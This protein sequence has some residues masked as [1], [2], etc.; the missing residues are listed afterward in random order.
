MKQIWNA[1]VQTIKL[2][3]NRIIV[4]FKRFSSPAYLLQYIVVRIRNFFGRL[5]DIRPKNKKDYYTIGG[6]MVSRRLVNFLLIL[7]GV[8]CLFYLTVTHPFKR[9]SGETGNLPVYKYSSISLR[10]ASG[11]VRIK[12]KEGYI[13]YEGE[14]SGGY[15]N[16]EGKLY[17]EEGTLV[18]EGAFQKNKYNGEGKLYY[19]FGQLEYTGT[20][21]DNLFEGTGTQYRESGAKLYE[22]TFENGM[23]EGTGVFYNASDSPVFTGSF[24]RDE[25]VYTQFLN[26]SAEEIGS[27]YTGGQLIYQNA[28]A[29][30]NAVV[31]SDIDVIYYSGDTSTSVDGTMRSDILC[32]GKSS[33]VYGNKTIDTIEGLTEVLGEPEYEGNSYMT[34]LEAVGISWM[35]NRGKAMNIDTGM[36]MDMVFDEVSVV[37]E[38]NKNALLYLHTYK[39]GESTYT[40][41]SENRTGAFFMYEI[42]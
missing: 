25:I 9:S 31:L 4:T 12:A 24:H 8:G 21:A 27:L 30:Q 1:L 39:I 14:V 36:S 7:A 40:F 23:R 18:Y 3:L 16:G 35:Q 38:Y 42:E 2:R 37:N 5:M 41:V 32:V 6:W 34:F 10:Y 13:A 17:D 33:F 29:T 19:P 11:K 26:K 15:V 28:E 20:F 22:G